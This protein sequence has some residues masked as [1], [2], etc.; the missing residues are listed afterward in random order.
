MLLGKCLIFFLFKL[1]WIGFLLCRDS[2][3][4]QGSP[5][6]ELSFSMARYNHVFYFFRME[7][8]PVRQV[9]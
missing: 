6:A 5:S 8:A 1:G 3:Y 7:C 4:F 2:E 9:F